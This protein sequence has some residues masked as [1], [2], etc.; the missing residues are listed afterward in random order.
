MTTALENPNIL[1]L[2]AG[3]TDSHTLPV[4]DVGNA[5][6][7]LLSRPGLPECLQY[8]PNQ[9]RPELCRQVAKRLMEQDGVPFSK[10]DSKK[11]FMTNGSQQAL[12]LAT[13]VLCDMGDIVF[14]ES[15]SYFVYLEMLKGQGVEARPLPIDE[16]GMIDHQ[17]FERELIA[18]KQS[19]EINRVKAVYLV[20]YFS[21]PS[22]ESR[23]EAEKVKL[24]ELLQRLDEPIAVIEDAAYRDLYFETEYPAR[25]VVSLDAFNGI[26]CLYLATLTKPFATGLK[27]GSGFC[28]DQE[29]LKRILWLKGHH[30][31]GSSN[32]T[33]AIL[34]TVFLDGGIDRQLGLIRRVYSEKMKVLH[35]ALCEEGLVEI[36]WKWRIPLG[37]LYLWLKAPN[38]LDTRMKSAFWKACCCNEVMYIPGDLCYGN[39]MQCFDYVRLSFGVLNKREMVEAATRFVKTAKDFF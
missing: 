37:G 38:S 16:A 4:L 14:V 25:S 39:T 24:G 10:E 23:S 5:V 33:Q 3:F 17:S 26:S 35:T 18:M 31:F 21:N 20:S 9:G 27:I 22:G 8:G 13:Q 30:D 34:E 29:W 12:F 28:T 11:V 15:P 19:G 6:K 1:S 2:A 36:G 32:F 7:D